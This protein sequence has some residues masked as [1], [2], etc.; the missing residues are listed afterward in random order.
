MAKKDCGC[1]AKVSTNKTSTNKTRTSFDE[2]N[3][4]NR[5]SGK[6]Y[7]SEAAESVDTLNKKT[8]LIDYTLRCIIF[9]GLLI[10]LPLLLGS[11][12]VLLF[13][14]VVLAKRVDVIPAV[15]SFVKN[16]RKRELLADEEN[17]EVV[18]E[19]NYEILDVENL[20]E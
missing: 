18:E 19:D 17:F 14:H 2:T 12:I 9:L 1:K 11:V 13:K 6:L 20:D 7:V 3:N 4:I 5:L 8:T 10:T 16:I 15:T